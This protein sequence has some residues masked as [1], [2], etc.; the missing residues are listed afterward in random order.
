MYVCSVTQ[1]TT[2]LTIT[3]SND[4]LDLPTNKAMILNLDSLQSIIA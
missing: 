2:D 4:L 1:A 3:I